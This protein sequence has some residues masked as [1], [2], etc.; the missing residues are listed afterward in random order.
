VGKAKRA[1]AAIAG[2][3]RMGAARVILS[4]VMAGLD[5]AI[6]RLQMKFLF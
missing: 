3:T 6:H 5:P 2:K 4:R 1:H